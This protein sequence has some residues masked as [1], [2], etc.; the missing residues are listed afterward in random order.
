MEYNNLPFEEPIIIDPANLAKSY[1]A[2]L[3][4]SRIENTKEENNILVELDRICEAA[5]FN[6]QYFTQVNRAMALP[7]SFRVDEKVTY[8]KFNSLMFEGKFVTYSIVKIG[9]IIGASIVRALC[10][11]FDDVTLLPFLDKLP[12]DMLLHVPVLAVDSMSRS[13]FD[14]L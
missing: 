13:E 4:G 9:R 11:S 10:L 12:N 6:G 7:V 2:R 5:N 1:V 8:V 3:D 14:N